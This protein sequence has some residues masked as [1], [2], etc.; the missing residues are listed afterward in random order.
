M[1]MSLNFVTRG[2]S[3]TQCF[4]IFTF[5]LTVVQSNPIVVQFPPPDIEIPYTEEQLQR[6]IRTNPRDFGAHFYLMCLYAQQDK[7]N[8]SLKHSLE[9]KRIDPSD[10]NVHMGAAY[11]YANL[12]KPQQALQV[13]DVALKRDFIAEDHASLWRVRGDILLERYRAANQ[14]LLLEQA[15][16]SYQRALKD[17][18][19]NAQ[20]QVGVARVEIERKRYDSARQR[21]RKVLEQVKVEE[22][23]G[24]RKRALALYY[25]GLIEERQK[26]TDQARKLYDQAVKLHSPSF[27]R[28][29]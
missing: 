5:I 27:V 23:G 22:P 6:A 4:L 24:R 3:M 1:A 13:I 17:Y 8:A 26:R 7:W 20:A 14:S 28:K 15:L 29:K 21:L 25:L 18:P 12:G 19:R 10:V 16:S 2:V 11:C 9:A